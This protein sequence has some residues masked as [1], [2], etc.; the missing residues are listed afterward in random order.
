M[1]DGK[2]V[3]R[4]FQTEIFPP[5]LWNASD[6]VLQ[7]NCT[8]A[9]IHGTMNTAADF[10]SRRKL[11]ANENFFL[12]IREVVSTQPIEVKIELTGIA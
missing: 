1:A 5:P 9:H 4:F 3:T 6:L 11:D 7:F 12:E 8:K 10:L 2:Q